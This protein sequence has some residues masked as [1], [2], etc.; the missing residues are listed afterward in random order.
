MDVEV[1][2]K[3]KIILKNDEKGLSPIILNF[4]QNH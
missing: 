3:K 4:F 1:F 2:Y